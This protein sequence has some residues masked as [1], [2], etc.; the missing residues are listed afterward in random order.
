MRQLIFLSAAAFLATTVPMLAS[1]LPSYD[2]KIE[3]AAIERL[4]SKLPALRNSYG[5]K[6]KPRIAQPEEKPEAIGISALLDD[7]VRQY[8]GRINWL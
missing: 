4:Q 3:Q 6:D 2:K 8:P 5:L 1:D 7:G